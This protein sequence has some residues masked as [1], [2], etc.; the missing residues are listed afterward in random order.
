MRSPGRM[1]VTVDNERDYGGEVC[2]QSIKAN[3]LWREPNFGLKWCV[4]V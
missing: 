1:R 2:L 4:S 3:T